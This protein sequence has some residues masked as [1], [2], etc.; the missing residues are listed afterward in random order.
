MEGPACFGASECD[1]TGLTPPVTS[2]SHSS[3]DGCT[4]IGGYVYRGR[5][6]PALTGAY[7]FGDYCQGTIWALSAADT[8]ARGT[9]TAE[10]VASLDGS[11]VSFG[12][13]DAGELYVVDLNGRVLR[14]TAVSR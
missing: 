9:A 5:A 4:I 14:M 13:D 1:Q 11:L 10:A 3:G 7:L 6:F 12:Q 2:Y 8:V